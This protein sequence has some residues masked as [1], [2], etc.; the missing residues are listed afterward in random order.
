MTPEQIAALAEEKFPIEEKGGFMET[1]LVKYSRSVFVLGYTTAQLFELYPTA[2]EVS[3]G[4]HS[5]DTP[6]QESGLKWRKIDSDNLP[7]GI[8]LTKNE[9]GQIELMDLNLSDP[10]FGFTF[11]MSGISAS[12]YI[13][14]TEL[15]NL[16]TE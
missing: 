7:K 14:L 6:T 16:P 8:V 5:V 11:C 1:Y 13:P 15:L 12:H 4:S 9:L 10:R 2:F 3:G